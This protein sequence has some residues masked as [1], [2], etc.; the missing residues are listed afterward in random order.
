MVSTHEPSSV[1][2][3]CQL[4]VSKIYSLDINKRKFQKYLKYQM[5]QLLKHIVELSLSSTITNNTL[6]NLIHEKQKKHQRK[7]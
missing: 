1:A 5:L 7:R 3:G 6:T 2:A 4:L